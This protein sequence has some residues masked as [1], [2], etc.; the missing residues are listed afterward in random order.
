[1]PATVQLGAGSAADRHGARASVPSQ[2]ELSSLTPSPS[3]SLSGLAGAAAARAAQADCTHQALAGQGW[4]DGLVR[5]H[6]SRL[7]RGCKVPASDGVTQTRPSRSAAARRRGRS[8]CQAR[9]VGTV[10]A[11]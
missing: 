4:A 8:D 11:A 2:P 3:P 5:G 1:M 10:V 9:A 7:W 6:P